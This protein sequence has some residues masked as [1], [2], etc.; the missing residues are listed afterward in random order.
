MDRTDKFF[1]AVVVV[2]VIA[3]LVLWPLHEIFD[4]EKII[5]STYQA[6]S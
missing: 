1:M 3:A 6:T 5:I 4:I 2:F